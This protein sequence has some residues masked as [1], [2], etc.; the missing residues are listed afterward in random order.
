MY[1]YWLRKLLWAFAAVVCIS[2][3]AADPLA[4][5]RRESSAV[6]EALLEIHHVYQDLVA[7]YSRNGA[8]A[9]YEIRLLDGRGTPVMSLDIHAHG[10]RCLYGTA[11]LTGSPQ[12]L[13]HVDVSDLRLDIR[14]QRVSVRGS[15]VI[16]Y[17][18][19]DSILEDAARRSQNITFDASSYRTDPRVELNS[20]RTGGIIAQIKQPPAGR[21]ADDIERVIPAHATSAVLYALCREWERHALHM[22]RRMRINEHAIISTQAP[23]DLDNRHPARIPRRPEIAGAGTP[24]TPADSRAPHTEIPDLDMPGL[25]DTELD[26]FGPDTSAATALI[27][28][29][30]PS[31]DT[32]EII[33]RRLT[34][35][36]D[37]RG[38]LQRMA[39][40]TANQFKLRR[41]QNAFVQ[42]TVTVDDPDFGPWFGYE[43]L[44]EKDGMRNFV[45]AGSGGDGRQ[46]WRF[47]TNW[48]VLGPFRNTE[49][50]DL[51]MPDIFP[52]DE[53][54]F[55]VVAINTTLMDGTRVREQH[56]TPETAVWREKLMEPG[57]GMLRPWRMNARG[58]GNIP[59]LQN[60]TFYLATTI[61]AEEDVELWAGGQTED[62]ALLWVN[63]RLVCR[64]PVPEGDA[65]VDGDSLFKMQL[66]AGEN[67][68]IARLDNDEGFTGM[69][70]RLC[71]RG[72]PRT[73]ASATE[74]H[75]AIQKQLEALEEKQQRITG[76]RGGGDGRFP[77]AT[78]PLVWDI[79]SGLNLRW[80][81]EPG[82]GKSPPVIAGDKIFVA[83]DPIFLVCLDKHTGEKLWKREM[84]ILELIDPEKYRESRNLRDDRNAWWRYIVEHGGINRGSD[85]N[86]YVGH[87]F[88]TPVTDGEHIWVKCGA[89]VV[90]CF[91]LDGNRKWMVRTD[92][93]DSG[94]SMCSSPVLVDGKLIFE[95][96]LKKH[97]HYHSDLKM[98]CLDA[99]TGELLW[100]VPRVHNVSP[101]STPAVMRLSN[102]QD[103]MA[104]VITGGGVMPVERD[105]DLDDVFVMGG[106]VVRVDDGHVLIENLGV[107]SGWSSPLPLKDRGFHV[108]HNYGTAVR[109]IMLDRD[110]VGAQ[111][112]WTRNTSDFSGGLVYANGVLHGL[113][114]GQFPRGPVFHDAASG[115]EIDKRV[116]INTLYDSQFGR[117]YTPPAYAGG[118]V[119]IADDGTYL[120]RPGYFSRVFVVQ[121]GRDGR[122][123]ARN[124]LE[125]NMMPPLVFDGDRIYARSN[126][127]L[128]CLGHTGEEGRA[129]EA[130]TVAAT[131]LEDLP[132]KPPAATPAHRV[133]S[134]TTA[135]RQEAWASVPVVLQDWQVI[136]PYPA[137]EADAVLQAIGGTKA[138]ALNNAQ[139]GGQPIQQQ[140]ITRHSNI[141][142]RQSDKK[143]Y[144]N[145]IPFGEEQQGQ[146][147]YFTRRLAIA[148][149]RTVR[150]LCDRADVK[151]WLSGKAV[152]NQERLHLGAGSHQLLVRYIANAGNDAASLMDLQLVDSPSA[153]AD[154]AFWRESVEY[155]RQILERVIE[156]RPASDTAAR[157]KKLLDTFAGM[158]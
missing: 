64:W 46:L 136:G 32:P 111:R 143:N 96:P 87:M 27:P 91:D 82:A 81:D 30:I 118:Y 119:F 12:Y 156:L 139:Y 150:V 157:A 137:D 14:G 18:L 38:H 4:E 92:Y 106:T 78:P 147:V 11:R 101:A 112:L 35:T 93:G 109:M 49:F 110:T 134:V 71:L 84:N 123:L 121:P 17:N 43:P 128:I 113:P 2:R 132:L 57:S 63:E 145:L 16:H 100:E 146:V 58:R 152:Q 50:V 15:A 154:I 31:E 51:H 90:A 74:R 97:E 104:V 3:A 140:R 9:M 95:L 22:Y 77:D 114:G 149:E 59:G 85:W 23:F 153:E 138:A 19:P 56:N 117:G 47:V 103:S 102:G 155:N 54:Y 83:V 70:L 1:G 36:Q 142:L 65:A 33:A 73:A 37:I 75:A 68:I 88:A 126:N 72:A 116:N 29:G 89:G 55:D 25:D 79:Q 60:A 86:N 99:A 21:T 41:E 133:E 39:R 5:L 76:M 115:A 107:S 52:V 48:K 105:D 135:F 124:R 108:G 125:V 34:V 122:L 20:S 66:Q 44:P 42:G 40:A 80:R 148:Q 130:E 69:A 158:L 6:Y 7:D 144:M 120:G 151:V 127:S 67:R 61:H 62:R 141:S 26:L 8:D 129:E 131:L 28:A 53:A 45:E 13:H 10:G 98:V 94:F 24:D